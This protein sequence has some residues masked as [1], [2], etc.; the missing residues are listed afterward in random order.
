MPRVKRGTKA[1]HRHK[2]ILKLAK[3]YVGGRRKLYRQARE[4]VEKGLVTP[5]ATARSASGASAACGS[6]GSMRRRA[7]A[8]SATANSSTACRPAGSV[9]TAR[10]SPISRCATRPASKKS[11]KSP[12]PTS[13]RLTAEL[14]RIGGF[15]DW[16]D[17]SWTISS[18]AIHPILRFSNPSN[19]S[20]RAQLE[21]IHRDARAALQ[22]ASTEAAV[23]QLRVRFLGRKG[24][25][26]EVV[27][28]LRDVPP[29]ERPALG[30]Y[31]NEI[32]DDVE[33]RVDSSLAGLR[34]AA[35]DRQVAAE[36][37]RRHPAGQLAASPAV[38]TP[39]P[40]RWSTSSASS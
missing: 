40:R 26:T 3:G 12:R 30:A 22:A 16:T 37:T 39:L 25:L 6:C 8:A 21:Q 10:C 5:T 31:L 15:G 11:H 33:H 4:T 1:R 7:S 38:S 34:A 23:E 17:W 13:P 9:S 28:G 14:P 2:K 27:R 35:R 32:K 20:M 18:S 29:A 19:S 36:R 24:L